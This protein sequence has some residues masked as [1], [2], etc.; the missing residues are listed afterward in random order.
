RTGEL[1]RKKRD[2]LLKSMVDDVAAHV[3]A[4]NYDQTLA[5][6]LLEADAAQTL[7]A[8]EAYIEDLERRGRLD[9]RIEGLPDADGVAVRA[10]SGRGLTRPEL[11]I[12]LAHAK[13]DLSEQIARSAAADD[14]ALVQALTGY[15]PAPLRTYEET[16]LRHPLRREIIATV[17]SNGLVD[18]CGPTFASELQAFGLCGAG[19]VVAGFEAARRMLELDGLWAEIRSL[20]GGL[21]ARLQITLYGAV[22]AAVRDQSRWLAE[23][24]ERTKADVGGLIGAY[25]DGLARLTRSATTLMTPSS[26]ETFETTVNRLVAEGT[27]EH[28][29]RRVTALP[30]LAPAILL[31]DLAASTGRS[32]EDL[33]RT[34]AAEAADLGLDRIEAASAA[35]RTSD[36]LERMALRRQMDGLARARVALAAPGAGVAVNRDVREGVA[37]LARLADETD[38]WTF[39]R[40]VLANQILAMLLGADRPTA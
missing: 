19:A 8:H 26:R 6:S 4:H 38:R 27:P 2:A 33:A 9:R 18:R 10:R 20:D 16:L 7:G 29:A 28:L 35:L 17:V 37:R 5:L 1:T 30:H 22:S 13:L 40:L 39:A 11:A 25:G 15:F 12:L 36:P 3:L 21:P 31:S 24:A 34:S 14:P 32:I 23:R